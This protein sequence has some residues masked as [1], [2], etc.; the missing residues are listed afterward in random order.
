METKKYDV[1]S[2]KPATFTY[3][4]GKTVW[5]AIFRSYRTAMA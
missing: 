3:I 2:P 5:S 1:V 4:S